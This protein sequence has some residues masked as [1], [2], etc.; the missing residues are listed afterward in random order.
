MPPITTES[1]S[2]PPGIYCHPCAKACGLVA[3][4]YTSDMSRSQ[5]QVD[6][7]IKHTTLPTSSSKLISVFQS[8]NLSE[9]AEY[10][11]STAAA[12]AVEVDSRG[13]RNVI[14]VFGRE[15]GYTFRGGVIQHPDDGMMLALSSD[16]L[17]AHL[18]PS[19]SADLQKATCSKCGGPAITPTAGL[20]PIN[21]FV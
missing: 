18:I 1:W 16:P 2:V 9:Y 5:Y 4:I 6:K 19:N 7:I 13:R 15:I 12:G 3:D 20:P 8:T 17:K 11:V 21:Y 10:V 14:W